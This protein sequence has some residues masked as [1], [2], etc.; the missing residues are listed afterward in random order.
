MSKRHEIALID[1]VGCGADV[2]MMRFERPEG[3]DFVA[4]QWMRLTLGTAEGDVTA[5]FTIASA[6]GDD[7]LEI[8][9]R[10]SG[11]AFKTAL[12]A[13][14]PGARVGMA[15][16]GG[17]MGLP[18]AG[19]V[20]FLVG[21]VGVTP[22]RSMLRDAA[23]RGMRFDDA[24]VVYGNRDQECAP[25]LEEFETMGAVGVR[26]VPVFQNADPRW[27]GER[28]FIT[29]E[30]VRRYTDPGDGRPYVV[31]GPPVM[32][33]VMNAVLDE[34]EISQDRRVIEWFGAPTT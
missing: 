6:P 15:G 31:A 26:V 21:G 29:A 3:F 13:L 18:G 34:L 11:S 30:L 4:G 33:A 16:P 23:Q 10:L 12:D 7:W 17:R 5:T 2:V 32:V 22:A 25:Y 27:G 19:R 8:A 24:L 20:A 28:G 1:R 9:T 14:E